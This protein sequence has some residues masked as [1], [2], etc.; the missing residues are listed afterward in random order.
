MHGSSLQA[1]ARWI[2]CGAAA[3]RWWPA[4]LPPRASSSRRDSGRLWEGSSAVE[5][6]G[7]EEFLAT[8][9]DQNIFFLIIRTCGIVVP[10][11]PGMGTGGHVSRS[12]KSIVPHRD[13]RPLLALWR[14]EEHT[15]EL[16]SPLN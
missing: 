15:S 16:Q 6:S 14:S 1:D 2:A 13:S 8:V 4:A 10:S 9:R 7:D 5:L 12:K 11:R 3:A